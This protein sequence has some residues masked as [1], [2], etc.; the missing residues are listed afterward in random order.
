MRMGWVRTAVT[1]WTAVVLASGGV[2]QA[3]GIPANLQKAVAAGARIFKD[4]SFGGHVSP[5]EDAA[6]AFASM[7]GPKAGAP[8]YVTC[9]TCHINGGLTRG[10]LANGKRIPSLR[11][12]AAIF[13]R[14][15]AK[16][17]RM[18]TLEAQIRHCVRSGIKG[19]PPAY[20]GQ[21]MA[22]LMSYLG[23]IAEGQ[24]ITIGGPA[25]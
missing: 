18:V 14:Y 3:A 20:G 25:S 2:A 8:R 22:D 10:R 13:P 9:A 24:R 12:A 6:R 11:N 4:D 7:G 19:R 16:T 23:S 17:H 1:A 5:V 21:T 15:N